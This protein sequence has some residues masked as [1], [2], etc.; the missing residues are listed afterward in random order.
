MAKERIQSYRD[1][2]AWRIAVD[3]TDALHDLAGSL[4]DT[5]RY[6]LRTQ[7]QRAAVSVPSNIAEG[8]AYGPGRRYA[9]HVRISPGSL[10]ELGTLLEV[11]ARRGYL[12][13]KDVDRSGSNS[14]AVASC[15]TACFALSGELALSRHSCG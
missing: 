13:R 15:S 10:G 8:Q 7:I 6:G 5:E 4:P 11:A 12:S 2:E 1:L 14:P 9:H 3:L